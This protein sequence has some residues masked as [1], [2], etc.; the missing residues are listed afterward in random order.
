MIQIK[1]ENPERWDSL[2]VAQL[3]EMNFALQAL[4]A[5]REVACKLIFIQ[6]AEMNFALQ[7]PLARREF[8]SK[9]I[10]IPL[11]EMNCGVAFL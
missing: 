2:F 8:A 6:L 11:T 7:A 4:L 3:A 9:L 5:R 1:K 10:F